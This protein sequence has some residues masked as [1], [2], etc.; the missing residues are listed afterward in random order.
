M[1]CNYE[2]IAGSIFYAVFRHCI[3]NNPSDKKMKTKNKNEFSQ[4]I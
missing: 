2:I 4:I 1:F 3:A